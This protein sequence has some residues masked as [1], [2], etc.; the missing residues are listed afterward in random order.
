ML[1]HDRRINAPTDVK[2]GGKA[3]IAGGQ[4]SDEVGHDAVGDSLVKRA[5]VPVGPDVLFQG[6]EFHAGRFGYIV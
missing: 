6:F 1:S 4:G 2:S 5:L 3:Q